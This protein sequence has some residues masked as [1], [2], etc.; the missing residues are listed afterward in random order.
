MEETF[1]VCKSTSRPFLLH[2]AVFMT[3]YLG[4][5][6]APGIST[7]N[8]FSLELAR[9]HS[10]SFLKLF[11]AVSPQFGPELGEIELSRSQAESSSF[12][13]MKTC[14]RKT[15]LPLCRPEGHCIILQSCQKTHLWF[16]IHCSSDCSS[17][18]ISLCILNIFFF[19]FKKSLFFPTSGNLIFSS[20]PFLVFL[21][22]VI[23]FILHPS[24][25]IEG[26]VFS[27]GTSSLQLLYLYGSTYFYA[28]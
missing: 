5:P 9:L 8:H 18:R 12:V 6:N 24:S 15:V 23:V 17:S 7:S 20:P 19:F 16:A 28:L 27:V 25:L 13:H 2:R 1:W 26:A 3:Q 21:I 4:L 22:S 14:K 10:F 11:P